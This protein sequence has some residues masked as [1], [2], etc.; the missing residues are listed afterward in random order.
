VSAV[1]EILA[2]EQFEGAGSD[3]LWPLTDKQQSIRDLG[4]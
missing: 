4:R 3:I 2:D 1:D